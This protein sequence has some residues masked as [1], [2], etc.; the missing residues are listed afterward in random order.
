[1]RALPMPIGHQ[2]LAGT[3][4]GG[5]GGVD[6]HGAEGMIGG[7]RVAEMAFPVVAAGGATV[8]DHVQ[9]AVIVSTSHQRRSI[10]E[11]ST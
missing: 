3:A 11:E 6:K 2:A 1:M 10:S 8:A 4:L 7:L 5:V 9:G